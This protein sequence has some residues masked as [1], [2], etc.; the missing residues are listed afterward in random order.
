MLSIVDQDKHRSEIS[1]LDSDHPKFHWIFRNIDYTQWSSAK[2]SGVLWLSGLPDRNIT[3]VSSYIVDQENE[4]ASETDH[5]NLYFF[6]ATGVRSRSIMTVF[7]HT[8]L[9][10]IVNCSPIGK[11]ISI[12]KNFLRSLL[13]EIFKKEAAP[14]WKDRGFNEKAPGKANI[15]KI[16][17]APENELLTALGAVLVDEGRR[18]LSV[19]IDG[20]GIVEHQRGDFIRGV[21]RFVDSTRQQIS[22]ARILLTSPPLAEVESLFDGLPRIEYDVERK[23]PSI[24]YP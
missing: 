6:C 13:E 9:N 18:S 11:R 1:P 24:Y 8:L 10:Q 2:H 15:K 20:L 16:L 7:V 21:R 22:K 4:A 19:V 17:N 3:Q 14:N 12:I 5:F 23:G